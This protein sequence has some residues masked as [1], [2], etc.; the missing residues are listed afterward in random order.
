M[1]NGTNLILSSDMD[2]D[3]YGKMTK[4]TRKHN[5]QES[6]VASLFPAGDHKKASEYDQDIPHSHTADQPTVVNEV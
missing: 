2:Q 4:N 3:T 1:F 6:Q 5:T